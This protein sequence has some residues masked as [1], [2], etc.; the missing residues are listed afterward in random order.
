[1]ENMTG[2]VLIAV[3]GAALAFAFWK[4]KKG[5]FKKGGGE[6]GSENGNE[7]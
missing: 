7:V 1:M 5:D 3:L 2:V 4:L 6:V